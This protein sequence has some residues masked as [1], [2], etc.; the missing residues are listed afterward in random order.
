[1]SQAGLEPDT[2]TYRALLSGYAKHGLLQD[3]SSTL[4]KLK[5]QDYF[6]FQ[7]LNAY[8]LTPIDE[9]KR[10]EIV[11]HDRDLLEVLYSAAIHEH[12]EIVDTLLSQMKKISGYNQDCYNVILRLINQRQEEQAFKVLLGMKPVTQA[13]GQT[14]ATGAFFIRQI[15]KSNC[16]PDKIVSFCQRLVDSGLNNRAFFRALEVAN[17]LGRV[18]IANLLL[19]HIQKQKDSL[20]PQAFWPLLVNSDS[21][22]LFY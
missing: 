14:T 20:R 10:K 19:K 13:D 17:T 2:E 3:I 5:F 22:K 12:Y 21:V 7:F 1:M 18:E 4:S 16:S 11:L 9:C 15:V 6:F 8:F